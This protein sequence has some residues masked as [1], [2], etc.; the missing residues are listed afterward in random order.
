MKCISTIMYGMSDDGGTWWMLDL[1]QC[2]G[3]RQSEVHWLSSCEQWS[4]CGMQHISCILTPV[5]NIPSLGNGNS[6]AHC[7][8]GGSLWKK[9]LIYIQLSWHPIRLYKV[10]FPMALKL[11]DALAVV[12]VISLLHHLFEGDVLRTSSV[13]LCL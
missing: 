12:V 6:L 4:T 8:W 5:V 9:T 2:G 10:W 13:S 1:G 7:A 11:E 3:V